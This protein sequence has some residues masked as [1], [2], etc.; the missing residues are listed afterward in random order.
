MANCSKCGSELSTIDYC[1]ISFC[2]CKKCGVVEITQQNF[3]LISK[4]IDNDIVPVDL[5]AVEP[6]TAKEELR[7]CS[8]CGAQMEKI[9]FNDVI[10]DRC[11]QCKLFIF[12]NGELSKY[13]SKL[14][15]VPME[16][17]SNAM[18][19]KTYCSNTNC[20]T[21]KQNAIPSKQEKVLNREGETVMQIQSKEKEIIYHP[22]DGFFVAILLF[23]GALLNVAV[24]FSSVV[25]PVLFG[26]SAVM[27][28]GL[29]CLLPGF[30]I[31]KPQEAYILTL[32]GKYVGTI[33]EAGFFWK[34]PFI[35]ANLLGISKISLKARTL[36]NGKQ[37]INDE[38]GNPIDVGIM[39]TWEVQDTAMAVFNVDNYTSFLSAQCDSVLR[40]II[41]QYPYDAP[42][43]S[44]KETLRGDSVE[45]S[46]KLKVE[47]QKAVVP[48]GLHIIDARI[49]HLAYSSEIAA[50]MLQRQ[51][52]NAIIAAKSAIV[53]GAVDMV[54]MALDKL[55]NS[56]KLKLDDD[57]KAQMVNNLLVVLCGNKESTPVIQLNQ[58]RPSGGSPDIDI[59][60]IMNKLIH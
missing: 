19:I 15:K 58:D 56:D 10:I 46:E 45:I 30:I 18:F 35:S 32:F 40:R 50:A 38:D 44:G 24:F 5:F 41:R 57:A 6:V 27:L 8:K 59:N 14:S 31:V 3:D 29:L 9:L 53:N 4:K 25:Y 20:S 13:Y 12:D 1:G 55:S 7:A 11:P 33:R 17:M 23:I 47:I 22:Y 16:I 28:I 54:E 34:N 49:T 2:I 39:V 43:D 42:E 52:A 21:Q 48:A 37:K 60:K 51:Q 26:I 36:D